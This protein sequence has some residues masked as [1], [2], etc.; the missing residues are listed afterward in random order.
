MTYEAERSVKAQS[1]ADF[2]VSTERVKGNA[3]YSNDILK[4]CT[5]SPPS[6]LGIPELTV[7]ETRATLALSWYN[8]FQILVANNTNWVIS[9]VAMI[10]CIQVC[11]LLSCA[12]GFLTSSGISQSYYQIAAYLEEHSIHQGQ[13]Q[14]TTPSQAQ[15]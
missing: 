6:G 2:S 1:S 10:P 9:L 12:R 5:A 3:D 14:I 7:L 15:R 13:R 11:L 8:Q 4:T